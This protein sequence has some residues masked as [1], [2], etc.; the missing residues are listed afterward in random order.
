[1]ARLDLQSTQRKGPVKSLRKASVWLARDLVN[2][3]VD[4]K[5]KEGTRLPPEA[6]MQNIFDVGRNTLRKALRLL[7]TRG[8]ITI[9][10][11][12]ADVI[13]LASAPGEA[14]VDAAL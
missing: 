13:G 1:M 2:F 11:G 14:E 3:I 8:V 6:E 7:E 4:G 10:T 5:L 12:R 9:R